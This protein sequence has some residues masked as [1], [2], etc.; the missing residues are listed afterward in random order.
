LVRRA[1]RVGARVALAV[2]LLVCALV[3]VGVLRLMAGPVNLDFLKERIAAA[4]DAPGNDVSPD[5]DHISLEWG[6]VSQPIRLVFRGLRFV[7]R[8]HQVI[9]SAPTAALTFDPRSVFRGMLLPTSIT[10]VKPTIEADIDREG[11][12]LRRIFADSGQQ[13][14]SE[15][16]GLLVEQLLAEPNY[17]SLVGQLDSIR[18]E[19]A[20]VT[21]RDVKTGLAWTAPDA[22]AE[23]KRDRRG[24][25][26]SASARFA[27]RGEPFDVGLDGVYTRDRSRISVEA[28]IQGLKPSIFA[29]LSPDVVLLR[30]LD[31]A[32]AGRLHIEADGRGDVRSMAVEVT[33]GTGRVTL[34]GV[35]PVTHR[36]KDVQARATV[37]T[38]AHSVS[39][40]RV[41][42]E[43]GAASVL[44]T[45]SGLRTH[46]EHSFRGRAEV[47]HI[48]IDRLADYWPIDFASG[49]RRWAASNLSNGELDVAADFALGRAPDGT[50]PVTLDRMSATLDY[51]DMRVR[52]MPDMPELEEVFGTARYE[53]GA[54]HFDVASGKAAGLSVK[55]VTIELEGLENPAGQI[56]SIRMPIAG[57][58]Q[59]VMRFLARPKLG[60]PRDVLYDYR[61][62]DGQ[63][64]IDLSL[65]FPLVDALAV[66]DI[67]IKADATVSH[68][69]LRDAIGTVDLSDAAARMRYAGSELAL[70][71]KGKLDGNEVD[72]A[73]R[74]M[75]GAKVPFRRRYD[76]KGTIPSALVAKAGFPS[77]EPYVSGPMAMTLGYQVAAS[78]TS[79]VTG[80]F[81]LKAATI[82]AAPLDWAKEP[83]ADALAQLTVRLAT[84]G[85]LASIDFEGRGN[86]LLAKGQARF[87]ADG[88]LQR[89]SLPQLAVG[90]TDV[91]I[92]WA[93][94][95]AGV[96]V[97]VRGAL[98][99]LPRVRHALKVRDQFASHDPGGAAAAAQARTRLNLQLQQITT[100]HG[101]LGFANGWL[102]LAADRIAAANL[103]L[104]GGKGA[105]LGVVPAGNGRNL[106]LNVADFGLLLH[107]AGWLD[108]MTS[109]ALQIEGHYDDRAVN[110]P[111]AGLLKMGPY[112]LQNVAPRPGVGTLN[113][114]IAG[115]GRA[116]NPLQ[117]FDGMQADVSKSGDRI[118]I[119]NGRTS[120][121]S[122]G[123]TTQGFVDL[124][125]DSARLGGVVV[126]AFALNNL[127]SNVPLL[128]PLLT[129]GKDAG[130]FA[131][132]YQL[133]GPLD[134]LKTSVNMMSAV[135]PGALRNLFN[136]PP[137]PGAPMPPA[138]QQQK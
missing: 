116:G 67:D 120:G 114:A 60:L 31:I 76:V 65:R 69:S 57:T 130:L 34:P 115:L 133:Y 46:Q 113:S 80:R 127:L 119:K 94:G 101:S 12:M 138:Q 26:I 79:E 36:V 131:V 75:F 49:G 110:S 48:P 33:G 45:G 5:V 102:E 58:A 19:Q 108:G 128:G 129:G 100:E 15:A 90:R 137:D 97:S 32:L 132:A 9:A 41:A 126:P 92:E 52:Y 56:A 20:T 53:T 93:R 1:F 66:A 23:L 2:V 3:V 17:K 84:G 61:R 124:G 81:D 8:Q 18:I 50:G 109:G 59:D 89:I 78:G 70:N 134:D 125:N 103:A 106:S 82:R 91:G 112:R 123:L 117:Q 55:D 104:G 25:V 43:F 7:N 24:V 87:A 6:G 74:E 42:L 63:A 99:E 16:L 27:G 83:G 54:L 14:Q 64:A 62:V 86:G 71:G 13:S 77:P 22:R 39:I 95:P 51:R 118:Q 88:A 111:F 73:W 105:T 47:R 122:I 38:A 44:I 28:M 121:A 35:L 107:Q 96:E 10:I 11:G 4:T 40:E 30:G 135:T 72:V 85:K 136:S 21:L 98:L 37:D 29:D 68:F